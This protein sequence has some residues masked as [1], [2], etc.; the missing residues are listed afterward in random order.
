MNASRTGIGLGLSFAL[1][2]IGAAGVLLLTDPGTGDR[3]GA[4]LDAN[5]AAAPQDSAGERADGAAPAGARR[6]ETSAGAAPAEEAAPYVGQPVDPA[7]ALAQASQELR[8]ALEASLSSSLDPEAILD[9][10]LALGELEIDQRAYS[11]PDP[12]GCTVYPLLGTPEGTRAEL[13]I[14]RSSKPEVARV[15]SLRVEL[16]PSIPPYFFEGCS[17]SMAVA[18]V[19][20]QIDHEGRPLNLT[21]LTDLP[22]SSTNRDLGVA[23]DQGTIPQGVLCC[24]DGEDPDRWTARAHG[25][26]DGRPGSW[27]QPSLLVAG[28][29]PAPDKVEAFR[30]LLQSKYETIRR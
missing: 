25:L 1:L 5:A 29:W 27:E 14:G 15:L 8:T 23:L 24:F 10:A 11:E 18:Q 28:R 3:P 20:M 13:W 7:A 22:P 12:S 6:Q 17:R 19:Q 4:A 2:A 21:I 9:A 26:S 16:D 30:G